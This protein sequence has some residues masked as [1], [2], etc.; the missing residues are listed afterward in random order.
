MK[1]G[2]YMNIIQKVTTG[3]ATGAIMTALLTTSTFAANTIKIKDNGKKSVNVAH[4][5]NTNKSSVKQ[6][7]TS[8][9][10][11]A[12]VSNTS[13]G[14]NTVKDNNGKGGSTINT[15]KATSNISVTVGG[16][17]NTHTG[18]DC[19][20]PSANN[21]VTIADN[22][23]KSVNIAHVEN[24]HESKVKQTNTSIIGTFIASN[25]E[26]GGNEI[27]DNNGKGGSTIDTGKA[28]SEITV[29]VTG[30]ENDSSM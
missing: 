21:D 12:V 18:D 22:G 2:E 8:I 7:N 20:C 26:T 23:K 25:T 29:E 15:G 6:S 24:K 30:S 13:T 28:E 1:G 3:L 16:S 11:T 17:S 27:K 4:V 5:T 9:I 19:G 10:G 14:G